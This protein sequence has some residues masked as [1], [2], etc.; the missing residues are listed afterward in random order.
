M[1]QLE[2]S[3]DIRILNKRLQ[4]A[5]SLEGSPSQLSDINEI[6]WKRHPHFT[7]ET[8]KIIWLNGDNNFS[9]L[10]LTDQE[11]DNYGPFLHENYEAEDLYLL[12][13]VADF[14]KNCFLGNV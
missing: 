12:Q 8:D 14:D 2:D 5:I 6:L 9:T 11:V 4:T 3:N 13:V 10:T 7:T 1:V